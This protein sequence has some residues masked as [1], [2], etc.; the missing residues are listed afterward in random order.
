MIHGKSS[1]IGKEGVV[2]CGHL[3]PFPELCPASFFEREKKGL[4][5]SFG[6][7]DQIISIKFLFIGLRIIFLIL[8]RKFICFSLCNFGSKPILSFFWFSARP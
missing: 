2:K 5:K 1:A 3:H 4:I 6:F 7:F 8:K